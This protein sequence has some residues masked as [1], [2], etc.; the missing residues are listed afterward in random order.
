MAVLLL[1]V[2]TL[3]MSLVPKSFLA[4]A[5]YFLATYIYA[6]QFNL[7][8]IPLVAVLAVTSPALYTWELYDAL[9][10]LTWFTVPDPTHVW[11][12]PQAMAL[13]RSASLAVLGLTI[14]AGEG[15]SVL[16]W[17]GLVKQS[18]KGVMPAAGIPVGPGSL[19]LPPEGAH[20]V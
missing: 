8:L 14:A 12:V 19:Q 4:I 7:T 2:Y 6:P 9:K 5:S 13:L 18:P 3:K 10:I 1:R 17:L 20:E 11:T 16:R 15:H